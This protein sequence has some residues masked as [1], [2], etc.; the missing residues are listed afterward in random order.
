MDLAKADVKDLAHSVQLGTLQLD[1]I[2]SLKRG[3]VMEYL[4]ANK[5]APEVSAAPAEMAA[6]KTKPAKEAKPKKPSERKP[7]K[8]G[9]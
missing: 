1:E 9:G 8:K 5:P 6:E 3:E 2:P 7:A 4:E